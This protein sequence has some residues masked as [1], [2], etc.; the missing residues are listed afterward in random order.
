MIFLAATEPCTMNVY[1]A[2][3][4]LQP[5][6][7]PEVNPAHILVVEQELGK[8]IL[9]R[10]RKKVRPLTF[11]AGRLPGF[12]KPM[13]P[14]GDLEAPCRV[15]LIRGGG[16]GDVLMATPAIREL[17]NRLPH[18]S[19]LTLA[20]F[21]SNVPLFSGNPHLDRVISE[22]MTLGDILGADYYLEFNDPGK[23]ITRTPM[24]DF[25]LSGLRIDPAE[26]KDKIPILRPESLFD[27][28]MAGRIRDAG[29]GFRCVVYLNGLASDR[30]RDVPPSI[31]DV[32]PRRHPQFLFL[33]PACF[34]ERYAGETSRALKG[35]NCLRVD[36]EGS[37]SAYVTALSC[38]D[39]V[40]TTDSSAYHL[41]AA[42]GK[43]ALALF[44]PIESRLRTLYYPTVTGL[45][46]NYQGM[47]CKSPCGKSMLSEFSSTSKKDLMGCPEAVRQRQRFSPCLFF[48]PELLLQSLERI[49][50]A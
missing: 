31:L 45:D 20:T 37:L 24:T 14:L 50:A 3:F 7:Y 4:T 33:V 6:T 8:R 40:I 1:E 26:V 28:V 29:S 13:P 10:D 39:A 42:L 30:L 41:A 32:L 23:L 38:S 5:L 34:C 17:R 22:P 9:Q 36:T 27:P 48:A 2:A 44:G 25:Y 16:I 19:H 11:D 35:S 46:A 43:P 21:R 15:I 47:T 12:P 18:G 49:L